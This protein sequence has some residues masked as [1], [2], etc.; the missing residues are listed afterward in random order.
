M[1]KPK[2]AISLDQ[3]LLDLI[4]SKVDGKSIRSRSQAIELFLRKGLSEYS[5]DTVV[6]MIRGDHQGV[7]LKQIDSKPLIKH[8]ID[9]LRSKGM[10]N[11][12]IVTQKSEYTDNFEDLINQIKGG[13]KIFYKEARGTAEAIFSIKQHLDKNFVVMSG[14]IYNIFDLNKMVQ[15][16]ISNNKVAT[17]GL[18]SRD[19]ISKCGVAVLEGDII[20][21]FSEKPKKT[22]SFVVNAGVYI[23]RPE[24]FEM[25]SNPISLE[26]DI[27]PKLAEQE[28]LIGFFTHGEYERFGE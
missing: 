23:F 8:Q 14:D 7:S 21:G 16:H 13:A 1:R 5:V 4:D 25:F 11:I 24:L 2:I 6:I 22:E 18:I 20:I 19:N 3:E 10:Q 12:Y 28:E 9:F 26:E 27:F 15:K 17:M